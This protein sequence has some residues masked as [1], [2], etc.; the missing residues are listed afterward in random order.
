M[1]IVRRQD[2][3]PNAYLRRSNRFFCNALMLLICSTMY[4]SLYSACSEPKLFKPLEDWTIIANNVASIESSPYFSGSDLIFEISSPKIKSKNKAIIDK[5]TG[6]ITINAGAGD[7]FD[8]VVTAQN[9]CG[10]VI[11]AFNVQIEEK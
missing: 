11:G 8:V 2:I 4:T 9:S 7:N 10:S 3:H 6:I 5:S 1:N